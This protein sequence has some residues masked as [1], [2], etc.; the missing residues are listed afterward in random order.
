VKLE[1]EN[2]RERD[3][4]IKSIKDQESRLKALANPRELRDAVKERLHMAVNA[5]MTFS[6]A[7]CEFGKYKK[8]CN[9]MS[10][11]EA[12]IRHPSPDS[13]QVDPDAEMTNGKEPVMCDDGSPNGYIHKSGQQG[14]HAEAKI[15]SQLTTDL[16]RAGMRD[17]SITLKIDWIFQE[18]GQ[19]V[20]SGMPCHECYRMLCFAKKK[21]NITIWICD[22]NN[23][24]QPFPGDCDAEESRERLC[25]LVD[26]AARAGHTREN[27]PLPKLAKEVEEIRAARAARKAVR[28][29]L[30]SALE[31]D[32]M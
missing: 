9:G 5:G 17:G 23:K 31:G 21:C 14:G 1:A 20:T 4:K 24:P 29:A 15:I 19:K 8:T 27:F 32:G 22:R 2:K 16:K 6:S 30:K 28:D 10:N 3:A 25:E 13:N 11:K 7:K 18:S 12:N 26:G